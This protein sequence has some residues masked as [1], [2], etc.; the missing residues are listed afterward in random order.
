MTTPY[1]NSDDF[2]ARLKN[3]PERDQILKKAVLPLLSFMAE[4]DFIF[5]YH[6]E[7][8]ILATLRSYGEIDAILPLRQGD[9]KWGIYARYHAPD[10][11]ITAD[12]IAPFIEACQAEQLAGGFIISTTDIWDDEANNLLIEA[13]LPLK[14]LYFSVFSKMR[15]KWCYDDV[16]S[17]YSEPTFCDEPHPLDQEKLIEILSAF[18]HR[19]KYRLS[20]ANKTGQIQ[21]ASM[22]IKTVVPENWS[23]VVICDD[24][25]ALMAC[26]DHVINKCNRDRRPLAICDDCPPL[27]TADILMPVMKS[28]QDIAH[29]LSQ[30]VAKLKG[31]YGQDHERITIIFCET[32]YLEE[33]VKAHNPDLTPLDLIINITS[34]EH[35][36]AKLAKQVAK[37]KGKKWLILADKCEEADFRRYVFGRQQW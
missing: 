27:L 7:S 8:A 34:K 16:N 25:A 29:S 4:M 24:F 19:D 37:L 17:S 33:F 15:M 9:D 12:H 10:T 11:A 14:R 26:S 31:I 32:R 3:D 21:I 18:L 30:P 20:R 5:L 6:D 35:V 13:C 2:L 28:P 1:L 22:T 23:A 36:P